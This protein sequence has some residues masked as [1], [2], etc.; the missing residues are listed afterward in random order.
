MPQYKL[1]PDFILDSLKDGQK[2]GRFSAACL[3]ID[4]SGF[5]PL[6][7]NLMQYGKAG[8]EVLADVLT[9]LFKPLLKTAHDYGGFISGFAGDG[10]KV[11][12][13][14]EN[15]N[16]AR[17]AQSAVLS[18][19]QMHEYMTQNHTFQT[20]FGSFSFDAKV[21]VSIGEV[22]WG[23]WQG[24]ASTNP[25]DQFR[26]YFIEGAAM[27]ECL[28]GDAHAVAGEVLFAPSITPFLPPTSY[29]ASEKAGFYFAEAVKL[30][31]LTE[32]AVSVKKTFLVDADLADSFYPSERLPQTI[33]EFRRVVSLF[34]NL[35]TMP[36]DESFYELFFRL[37]NQYG[38][39]LC[40]IGRIGDLDSGG[41]LHIFWGAPEVYENDI[42]RAL[43]FALDL[44][45][46]AN[47][48]MRM[49]LSSNMAFAG[50]VGNGERVEYTCYSSY[51]NL[52]ARQMVAAQWNEILVD[53][54]TAAHVD[55]DF[56][57]D[58]RDLASFKGFE[59][60]R[61][62]I[63]L[64]RR[65]PVER[66]PFFN[67]GMIGRMQ[68]TAVLEK[69]ISPLNDG[70]YAGVIAIIGE[71]G[72]GK[73]RIVHDFF[74][75]STVLDYS[76]IFLLQTDEVLRQS[77]N[78]FR[79]MLRQL[80]EQSALA[81]EDKNIANFEDIFD[82]IVEQTENALQREL[83]EK[84]QP[85]IAAL[86]GLNYRPELIATM[87]PTR[88]FENT[89]T[90]IKA[91][92]VRLCQD[93]GV[94]LHLE[95]AH[96][97]D[98]DSSEMLKQL[99]RN[100]QHL[101]LALVITSRTPLPENLFDEDVQEPKTVLQIRPLHLTFIHDFA[102]DRL[103]DTASDKLIKEL[104]QRTD[105]NPFFMEQLLLYWQEN[106][107]LTEDKKGAI[108]LT[109]AGQAIP[110]DVRTILVARIDQLVQEVRDVVQ[111]GAILGREFEIVILSHILRHD[112]DLSDKVKEAEKASIWSAISEMHY[113]FK[114]ALMRDI[115]YEMQ[116]EARLQTLHLMAASAFLQ[117]FEKDLTPWAVDL[118]YHFDRGGNRDEAIHW[119]TEAGDRAA[120]GYDNAEAVSYY[121]RALE[122]LPETDLGA[123]YELLLARESIDGIR[124]MR[125]AQRQD[126][127]LLQKIVAEMPLD[128]PA[129]LER[130][131][132]LAIREATYL[133]LISN[134]AKAVD[135]AQTAVSLA[136][137]LNNSYHLAQG[138]IILGK[139]LWP[140]SK[141][142]E[143][144]SSLEKALKIAQQYEYKDLEA[145]SLR[146]LGVVFDF[147]GLFEEARENSLAALDIHQ[148]LN[149]ID[150]VGSS[151]NNI[152]I[153]YLKQGLYEEA[154]EALLKA[155]KN[156][157]DSGNRAGMSWNLGNLGFVASQ[158]GDY[159]QAELFL[160]EADEI[161]I[162]LGDKWSQ[163]M[164]QGHLGN[165]AFQQGA[166]SKALRYH[167]TTLDGFEALGYQQGVGNA[168]SALGAL[169]IYIGD[170]D[171]SLAL[172]HAALAFFADIN[173]Q[174][175]RDQALVFRSLVYQLMGD[176]ENA[177]KDAQSALD[178][179][180][181]REDRHVLSYA[182]THLAD[183]QVNLGES[184]TA[185][186]N[187]QEAIE[188]RTKYK[189]FHLRVN[190]QAGLAKLHL[191]SGEL[192]KAVTQIDQVL[193]HI[194]KESVDGVNLPSRV[195][196][197]CYQVLEEADDARALE[198]LKEAYA[199]LESFAAKIDEPEYKDQFWE[200]V[201][202]NKKI[203]TAMSKA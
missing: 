91:L 180:R 88:R 22:E 162:E 154:Q 65:Q 187:Y 135:M 111:T 84:R 107:Y 23:I 169:W 109:K 29:T 85:F 63:A 118:A 151:Y 145:R 26:A 83:L 47:V 170:F 186:K 4:T 129:G 103:G 94:I 48:E 35:R 147:Q 202:A 98:G 3:F 140:Q 86:L 79:Y 130:Q 69:A 25:N 28:L 195:Y 201:S 178:G 27:A 46:H 33:G 146:F 139:A 97:L 44:R 96:W 95:D 99:F 7:S 2:N 41:T 16:W 167:T 90:G 30:D 190:S 42:S 160:R 73:S 123:R 143:A 197:I 152:G 141:L 112:L 39:Y 52:A 172:Y 165:V 18:A 43:G 45:R 102:E 71:A 21:V 177:A 131:T 54:E 24:A 37:L 188:L 32:T 175:N 11:V 153:S 179:A 161:F 137:Q 158:I 124:G 134:G 168:K 164:A 12:F 113:L 57:F 108:T 13:T 50:Y 36:E 184:E 132:E 171:R 76:E 89:V 174:R 193:A 110:F 6:T 122:L 194:N 105:G 81:S 15:D 31:E 126:L 10:L 104:A 191:Q 125:E 136:T 75:E 200:N 119:Y 181:E 121:S 176:N 185:V 82:N 148:E 173:A 68:E 115:A 74:E 120:T 78:P 14:V 72:I 1:V 60:P 38:G 182:L 106:N 100:V 53:S 101:P 128:T 198:V 19:W 114:H 93:N 70:Q 77:L 9:A 192:D 59:Q 150:G 157:Q 34:V 116:L 62:I 61:P 66:D 196:W 49:G 56:V 8:V 155:L 92:I 189:E 64:L 149:E 55:T 163:L 67:G 199:Y 5:T 51:V 133:D 144:Q 17:A 87:E 159:E 58:Y 20:P 80:F 156:H 117:V 166:F 40:R 183:A 142:K 138:Y 203:K 127:D